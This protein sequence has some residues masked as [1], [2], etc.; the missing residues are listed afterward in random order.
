MSKLPQKTKPRAPTQPQTEGVLVEEFGKVFFKRRGLEIINPVKVIMTLS[1]SSGHLYR[2][3]GKT[4]ITTKGY[5]FL[6]RVAAINTL[7]PRE[8]IIDGHAYPNPHIERDPVSKAILTANVRVMGIGYSPVGNQVIIDR[9]VYYNTYTYLL[10]SIMAKM[11][12]VRYK[13][14]KATNEK[15]YPNCA[16]YG[17]SDEPPDKLGKWVFLPISAPLGLWVNYQ[18]EAI[19]ACLEEHIQRQ[20]FGDRIAQSIAIRNVLKDHPAIGVSEVSADDEGKAKVTVYAWRHIQ[21]AAEIQTFMA[22]VEQEAITGQ[23]IEAQVVESSIEE[24][25]LVRKEVAT[26]SEEEVRGEEALK[27]ESK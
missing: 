11:N 24:E 21:S 14:G 22:A 15:L 8:I 20:R 6:N 27:G 5:Q 1:E 9:T 25:E 26:D 19:Q 2:V 16:V 23:T 18:D 10:Q 12:K 4:L 17:A 13:D 3:G 7:L